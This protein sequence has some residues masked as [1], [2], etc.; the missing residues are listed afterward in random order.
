MDRTLLRPLFSVIKGMTIR[1]T[2]GP[3]RWA[4]HFSISDIGILKRNVRNSAVQ[5]SWTKW[6]KYCSGLENVEI[7]CNINTDDSFTIMADMVNR[8]EILTWE[9][10]LTYAPFQL[11]ENDNIWYYSYVNDNFYV[12]LPN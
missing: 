11:E 5:S 9:E 6:S 10:I 8:D 4:G 3:T 2:I 7:K 12:K 1:G